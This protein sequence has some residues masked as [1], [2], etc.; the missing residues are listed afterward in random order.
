MIHMKYQNLLFLK[1]KK[2]IKY[3]YHML[4]FWMALY[5]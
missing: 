4:Q 2:D 3:M 5:E 1:N